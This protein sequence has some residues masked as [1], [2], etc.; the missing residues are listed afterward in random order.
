MPEH[1]AVDFSPRFK[2]VLYIVLGLTLLALALDVVCSVFISHPDSAVATLTNK[3][4]TAWIAGFLGI[5][6]LL[7]GNSL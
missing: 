3:L 2:T 1:V 6:G 4:G 7:T 5:V